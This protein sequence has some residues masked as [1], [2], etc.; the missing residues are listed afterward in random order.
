MVVVGAVRLDSIMVVD[1]AGTTGADVVGAV[2]LDTLMVVDDAGTTGADVVGAVLLD[3]LMVVD[4][5]GT[6]GADVVGDAAVVDDNA[7][8]PTSAV[9][10]ESPPQAEAISSS[11]ATKSRASMG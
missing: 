8:G 1:D 9:D 11:A 6:T 5:A 2:L 7:E 4:D 3:T 10:V